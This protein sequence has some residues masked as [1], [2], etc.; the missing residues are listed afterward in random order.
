ME[1]FADQAVIAIENA[2]LFHE[3]EE[4]TAQLTRSVGEL[5]ALGRSARRSPPHWT[6]RRC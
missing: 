5:E 1:T 3:L 2:R 4:R 6:S